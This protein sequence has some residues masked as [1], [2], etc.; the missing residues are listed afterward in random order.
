MR[1]ATIIGIILIVLGGIGLAYGG[2]T[3]TR[4]EEVLD[5]GPIEATVEDRETVAIPLWLSGLVLGAGV[6]LVVM[7]RRS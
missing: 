3:Y 2:F 1:P 7:G 6:V 4:E 5:V